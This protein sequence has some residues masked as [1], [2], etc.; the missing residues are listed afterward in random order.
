MGEVLIVIIT[1]L[2]SAAIFIPVGITI[3]K[4]I[5]ESKIQSAENEAKRLLE[6]VK[7]E[8]ENTKREEIFK[9]KEEMLKLA[10]HYTSLNPNDYLSWKNKIES[11]IKKVQ[12]SN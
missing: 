10:K 5:A 2:I 11:A 4:R 6:N 8:A 9:A 7:I 1:L 3:R 12:E